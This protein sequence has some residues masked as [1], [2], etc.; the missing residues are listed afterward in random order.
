[1]LRSAR[2]W[3]ATPSVARERLATRFL[4]RSG[5]SATAATSLPRCARCYAPAP[6]ALLDSVPAPSAPPD[7]CLRLRRR[8]A[9]STAASL[10]ALL[11][12]R[13]GAAA[14][15]D[16]SARPRRGPR[17][18]AVRGGG[19]AAFASDADPR[20]HDPVWPAPACHGLLSLGWLLLATTLSLSR[21]CFAPAA[22]ASRALVWAGS[23]L[24][25]PVA[26]QAAADP[27]GPSAPSA[28]PG[29]AAGAVASPA[30]GLV[31]AAVALAGS[32]P[33]RRR[34][35]RSRVPRAADCRR[36]SVLA[37]AERLQLLHARRRL[38]GV[39]RLHASSLGRGKFRLLNILGADLDRFRDS[40]RS[41][42]TR[43]RTS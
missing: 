10:R 33:G 35:S 4:R 29:S 32:L 28:A 37:G 42:R 21:S 26:A 3:P 25:R 12:T 2:T 30:V 5:C 13:C 39:L 7:L 27:V 11:R 6:A 22:P 24:P 38:D 20:C 17:W 40:P 1:V 19:L 23:C 41:R 36:G 15:A 16:A 8:L 18:P 31:V 9:Q 14:A 43:G 34:S